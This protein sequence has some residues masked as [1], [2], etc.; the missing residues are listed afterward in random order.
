[1]DLFLAWLLLAS[2]TITATL[3]PGPAFVVTVKN[4]LTYGRKGGVFTAMGLGM[5]VSVYVTL[6]LVG[7]A[8]IL[9]QSAFIFNMIK[10]LGAAYLV[11]IGIKGL[12][13]KK[14]EN[15]VMDENVTPRQYKEISSL[16]AIKIGFLTNL[17]NPKG[18]VFY[19]AVY[20]QFVG[21]DTPVFMLVIYGLTSVIV[22]AG[23]FGIL[24]CILTHKRVKNIFDNYI[25]W[26]ERVCGGL[27]ASLGVGLAL[28]KG[29]GSS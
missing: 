29:L 6:V 1:M 20:I 7:A 11:F 13:A 23:W 10:Y 16:K 4:S 15:S 5:G 22:E 21:V 12:M 19:S 18:V 25:H 9:T 27:L 28:S 3:S 24:S 17:L 2:V 14:V 8:Y 26:V